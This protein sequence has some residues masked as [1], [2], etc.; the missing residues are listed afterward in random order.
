MQ[1][2]NL[3]IKSIVYIGAWE[4]T[5]RHAGDIEQTGSHYLQP[6][7]IS[8]KDILALPRVSFLHTV[9]LTSPAFFLALKESA[10]NRG[11][12]KFYKNVEGES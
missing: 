11:K 5:K 1:I 4:V 6:P 10:L 7:A 12:L 9:L 8:P 2:A 3:H